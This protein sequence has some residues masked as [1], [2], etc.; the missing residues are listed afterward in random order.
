M[1]NCDLERR[2]S[3]T[4][5]VATRVILLANADVSDPENDLDCK[6]DPK[7]SD[8][9]CE[10]A[11]SAWHDDSDMS[12]RYLFPPQESGD[13]FDRRLPFYWDFLRRRSNMVDAN[14]VFI[15]LVVMIY[16]CYRIPLAGFLQY[17]AIVNQPTASAR[18]GVETSS[19]EDNNKNFRK[20]A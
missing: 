10:G 18:D 9:K 15:F 12:T 5:R 2:K 13:G 17:Q 19:K 20:D 1:M 11:A 6:C 7:H 4:D 16:T 3:S 14:S 8:S